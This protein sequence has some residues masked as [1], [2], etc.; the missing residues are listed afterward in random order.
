MQKNL[1]LSLIKW[2]GE[3][4]PNLPYFM[5]L[6]METKVDF[7]HF[8]FKYFTFSP[9]AEKATL[10]FH[11]KFWSVPSRNFVKNKPLIYKGR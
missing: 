11:D 10:G 3:S 1:G 9:L 5:H 4:L 7:F 2:P 6:Y 8:S